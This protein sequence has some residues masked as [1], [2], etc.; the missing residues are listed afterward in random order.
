MRRAH[1]AQV[2]PI[3]GRS[4]RAPVTPCGLSVRRAL[5]ITLVVF[6][7]LL[8]SLTVPFLPDRTLWRHRMLDVCPFDQPADV[9]LD[10]ARPVPFG[11][12][13]SQLPAIAAHLCHPLV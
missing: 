13:F 1:A 6:P 4:M 3:I 11:E 7:I 12:R 9:S 10:I 2:M 8:L 5:S